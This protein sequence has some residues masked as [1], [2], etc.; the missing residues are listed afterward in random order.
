MSLT[1]ILFDLDGGLYK[2]LSL[3]TL[4]VGAIFIYRWPRRISPV[5]SFLVFLPLLIG[6][7][8]RIMAQV[9]FVDA[10]ATAAMT[11]RPMEPRRIA[12]DVAGAGGCLL[13]GMICTIVL[14]IE[15]TLVLALRRESDSALSIDGQ[16][17]P[18]H[19]SN[20]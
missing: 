15:A 7:F 6:L 4:I 8:G 19:M 1:S 5:M 3:L 18:L 20:S 13:F 17:D 10:L 16:R 11:D 2:L 14:G 12:A 9:I